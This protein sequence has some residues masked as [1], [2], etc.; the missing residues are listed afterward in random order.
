MSEWFSQF[1]VGSVVAFACFAQVSLVSVLAGQ[2][3][4]EFSLKDAFYWFV[5]A[6][7]FAVAADRNLCCYVF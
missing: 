3:F 4:F 6:V 1:P 2:A 5:A 7:A